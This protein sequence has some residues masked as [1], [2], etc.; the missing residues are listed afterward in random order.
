M[1]QVHGSLQNPALTGCAPLALLPL[2]Q[3]Q[4]PIPEPIGRAQILFAQPGVVARHMSECFRGIAEQGLIEDQDVLVRAEC[5]EGMDTRQIRIRGQHGIDLGFC[6]RHALDAAHIV[7]CRYGKARLPERRGIK[8]RITRDQ[9]MQQSGTCTSQPENN[10]GCG[11]VLVQN[12]RMPVE[13]VTRAQSRH[14]NAEQPRRPVVPASRI[15]PRLTEQRAC[16]HLQRLGAVRGRRTPT[17][18]SRL[19]SER[20][21]LRGIQ[22]GLG[23]HNDSP[24]MWR[25]AVQANVIAGPSVAPGPG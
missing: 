12:F 20:E 7:Q 16:Q 8:P 19:R 1:R 15:Q 14:E 2:Q 13:P 18:Q 21:Q 5:V 6:R 23:A 3:L 22:C 11:N 9:P 25:A 17:V 4:H 10:D 24:A